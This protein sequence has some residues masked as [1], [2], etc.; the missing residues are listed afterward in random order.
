M[1]G[2]ADEDD[3]A[4]GTCRGGFDWHALVNNGWNWI[5]DR[6]GWAYECSSPPCVSVQ[7]Q[8]DKEA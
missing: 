6:S 5:E 3:S 8:P 2:G 7:T 4:P 1:D